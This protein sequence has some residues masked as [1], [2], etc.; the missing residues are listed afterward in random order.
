MTQLD[1]STTP[2]PTAP[3]RVFRLPIGLLLS[4]AAAILFAVALFWPSVLATHDPYAL[5]L[6]HALHAPSFEFLFGTDESGRDLYSRVIYGTGL[7]LSIGLGATAV[8]ITLAVILGSIAALAGRFAAG[9]VNRMIEI[10]FAF[11]TLLLA[12]LIVAILGPSVMSQILAV[13]IGTA[14][15]Y[16]RIIRGQI[17]SAKGSGYVEAATA[18]GHSRGLILRQHILPNALRPLVA[19]ITLSV[20]QSIVWASGLSF[21]G[22]GVAPPSP[23]WGALLDAG[24]TYITQAWWLT[25]IPGLVIVAVALSA[26]TL[27]KYLQ[28]A[29]EKG[30][31]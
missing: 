30:E 7:S 8:S 25:V 17:L 15:G 10:L 2:L 9:T 18:L 6:T 14:P 5:N 21:L 31:K 12:L 16:A 22:L 28:N 27:G 13:G 26:T 11:P 29:I 23:E 24:K 3:R 19:I 1:Q 4:A 20:G